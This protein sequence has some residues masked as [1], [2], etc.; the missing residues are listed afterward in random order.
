MKVTNIDDEGK[1]FDVEWETRLQ[2]L[3]AGSGVKHHLRVYWVP[4]TPESPVHGNQGCL[5]DDEGTPVSAEIVRAIEASERRYLI[6][7]AYPD[8]LEGEKP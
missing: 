6:S 5:C 8:Y 2:G 3:A 7:E 1:V 4:P